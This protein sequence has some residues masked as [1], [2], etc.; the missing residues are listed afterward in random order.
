MSDISAA[1]V[2][3][4]VPSTELVVATRPPRDVAI[5]TDDDDDDIDDKMPTRDPMTNKE[6]WSDPSGILKAL[7]GSP[8]AE[9]RPQTVQPTA[10]TT[11]ASTTDAPDDEPTKKVPKS[12]WTGSLEE[13]YQVHLKAWTGPKMKTE[14]LER[15]RFALLIAALK[16]GDSP[17]AIRML[18]EATTGRDLNIANG[19]RENSLL[20]AMAEAVKSKNHRDSMRLYFEKLKQECSNLHDKLVAEGRVIKL[21]SDALIRAA[22]GQRVLTAEAL[23]RVRKSNPKLNVIVR[24]GKDMFLSD[25]HHNAQVATA[26]VESGFQAM[27]EL[28]DGVTAE[29]TADIK[30]KLQVVVAASANALMEYER[31]RDVIQR[32]DHAANI[33]VSFDLDVYYADAKARGLPFRDLRQLKGFGPEAMRYE[34]GLIGDKVTETLLVRE[35]VDC[36]VFVPRLAMLLT[37]QSMPRVVSFARIFPL[38]IAALRLVQRAVNLPTDEA[39]ATEEEKFHARFAHMCEGH[40]IER[41]ATGGPLLYKESEP[42]RSLKTTTKMVSEANSRALIA[43]RDHMLHSMKTASQW[44]RLETDYHAGKLTKKQQKAVGF[45][46]T[47]DKAKVTEFPD[48]IA[49]QYYKETWKVNQK[50][51][52]ELLRSYETGILLALTEYIPRDDVEYFTTSLVPPIGDQ[53]PGVTLKEIGVNNAQLRKWRAFDL[54]VRERNTIVDAL[55]TP[56][57]DKR[58]HDRVIE[59]QQPW[60]PTVENMVS[61]HSVCNTLFKMPPEEFLRAF[62]RRNL[63]LVQERKAELA[64]L[65][66]EREGRDRVPLSAQ[67][68]PPSR[69]TS[70]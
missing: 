69:Q 44:F 35:L 23:E 43:S 21:P 8:P 15:R 42:W 31:A 66:K 59:K 25:A 46:P 53:C 70:S 24:S 4:N 48:V 68:T 20:K 64:A 55:P 47:F 11:S 41:I 18:R 28:N 22:D 13:A 3:D 45:T 54:D 60:S 27:Q 40:S 32:F 38:Y 14:N 16:D 56:L 5:V 50:Y 67:V 29:S 10:A 37:G 51:C 30:E 26:A 36:A 57:I 61:F 63:Q 62:D 33:A 17:V 2:E 58:L 65:E 19:A 49:F 1:V 6:L 34:M 9:Q 12:M 39:V 7:D 52:I